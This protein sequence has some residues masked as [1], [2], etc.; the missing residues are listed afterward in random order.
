MYGYVYVYVCVY[1]HTTIQIG[2]VNLNVGIIWKVGN[3]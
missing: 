3:E 2:D 1:I